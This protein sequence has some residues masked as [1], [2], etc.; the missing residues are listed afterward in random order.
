ME[1]DFVFN[2]WRLN[3]QFPDKME[4]LYHVATESLLDQCIVIVPAGD[5][6]YAASIPTLGL[7]SLKTGTVSEM[8][9]AANEVIDELNKLSKLTASALLEMKQ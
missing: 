9:R 6:S 5:G 7:T 1:N 3:T 4:A 8:L 2:G